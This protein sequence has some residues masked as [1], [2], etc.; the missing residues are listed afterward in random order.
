MHVVPFEAEHF[1]L[2]RVQGEQDWLSRVATVEDMRVLEGPY[3]STLM[4]GA[5][6]MACAGV[7]P[8]WKGR[9]YL[10]SFLSAEVDRWTFPALHAE[11]KR[12]LAGLPFTRLEASVDVGFANGHRWLKAL[13]FEVETPLQRKFLETGADAVGYVRIR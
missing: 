13:G 7:V 5:R 10:W 12:F 4:V 11:A 9:G 6:P 8:Y 1:A 2:M 3:S